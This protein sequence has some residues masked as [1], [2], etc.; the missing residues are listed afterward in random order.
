LDFLHRCQ[1]LSAQRLQ[2]DLLLVRPLRHRDESDYGYLVRVSAANALAPPRR[3]WH[4]LRGDLTHADLQALQIR[5]RLSD[6]GVQI[7][8]MSFTEGASDV[9]THWLPQN[10]LFGLTRADFL[11]QDMR[12]CA[13]CLRSNCY[14]RREW[15]L[16]LCCACIEH[17]CLLR[18]V[19]QACGARQRMERVD[20]ARCACGARLDAGSQEEI[21]CAL[22]DLTAFIT[23]AVFA[24]SSGVAA[25]SSRAGDWLKLVRYLGAFS[26]EQPR[27]AKP[28]QLAR[29]DDLATAAQ[30]VHRAAQVL[31]D[32]PRGLRALLDQARSTGA[33]SERLAASFGPIYAVLYRQLSAPCFQ[34]LRDEFEAYLH[35]HWWGLLCRRNRS[36]KATTIESHPRL[37]IKQAAQRARTTTTTAE[38]CI[39]HTQLGLHEGRT[40]K[41]RQHRTVPASFVST[42]SSTASNIV[43]LQMAAG[44]LALPAV[45]V[46]QLLSQ[47]LLAFARSKPGRPHQVGTQWK[48]HVPAL[49]AMNSLGQRAAVTAPRGAVPIRKLARDWHLNPAEFC[50]LVQAVMTQSLDA[51]NDNAGSATLGNTLVNP[52]AARSLT[53]Q[54]RRADEDTMSIEQAAH[55]LE[56]KQQVA[57]QLVR[58]D[59]LNSVPDTVRGR[60]VRRVDVEHFRQEY[61]SLAEL[62]TACATS[63]KAWMMRAKIQPVCGPR[64]DGVRQ[65]FYRRCEAPPAA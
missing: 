54:V 39:Q 38:Q 64:V 33:S 21:P 10:S 13:A 51:W 26:V 18:D 12:W 3:L 36:L 46:R 28:G 42:L 40:A 35:D 41:G 44:M 20:L 63:P 30:H 52:A 56:V 9:P 6:S 50:A 17:A 19:C 2:R 34:F 57:Y 24:P 25:N 61:V 4:A 62:A 49:A 58:N 8:Q 32:W 1:D 53:A 11:Q 59:F 48:I 45:R 15:R 14:I 31:Q 47:G 22:A 60:R 27:P 5:L 7:E 29:L 16:K 55:A 37:S 43:S 65:Y 23:A